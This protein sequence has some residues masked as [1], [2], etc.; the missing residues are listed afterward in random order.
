MKK[1]ITYAVTG[2]M[3]TGKSH[4]CQSLVALADELKF[5]L[6]YISTDRYRGELL[7]SNLGEQAQLLRAKLIDFFGA[8]IQTLLAMIQKEDFVRGKGQRESAEILEAYID[9]VKNIFNFKRKLKV[10]IDAGIPFLDSAPV[11]DGRPAL[12]RP[13]GSSTI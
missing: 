13:N 5:P 7:E 9:Y 1:Q 2:Q 4:L 11:K 10:V 6:S 8:E 12:P 3:G